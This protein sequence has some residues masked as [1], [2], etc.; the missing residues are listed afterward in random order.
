M[1][2]YLRTF[3]TF[4]DDY[5]HFSDAPFLLE[6]GCASSLSDMIMGLF[7]FSIAELLSPFP[8]LW[9][10]AVL[11]AFVRPVHQQWRFGQTISHLAQ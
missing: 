1:T 10:L 11:I 8:L 9:R 3:V 6:L 5:R 7:Y 2:S 4:S